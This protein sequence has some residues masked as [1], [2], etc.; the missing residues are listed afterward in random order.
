MMCVKPWNAAESQICFHYTI[1]PKISHCSYM[2]SSL[3]PALPTRH[4]AMINHP[5][6]DIQDHRVKEVFDIWSP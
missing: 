2:E 3:A 4:C 5:H 6:P 1:L